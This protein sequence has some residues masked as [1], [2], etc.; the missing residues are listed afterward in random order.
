MVLRPAGF[1]CIESVDLLGSPHPHPLPTSVC[2]CACV[3]M[4]AKLKQLFS[5]VVSVTFWGWGLRQSCCRIHDLCPRVRWHTDSQAVIT[6]R[7][8]DTQSLPTEAVQ[9]WGDDSIMFAGVCSVWCRVEALS[10]VNWWFQ[11]DPSLGV[12]GTREPG[13]TSTPIWEWVSI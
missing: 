10:T 6:V 8:P 13:M 7:F 2:V 12:K 9:W 11:A 1:R 4:Y 3:Y 5:L